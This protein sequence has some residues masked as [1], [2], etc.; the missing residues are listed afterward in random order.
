MRRAALVL[1]LGVAG[2][3]WAEEEGAGEST[4]QWPTN[5]DTLP[6][7]DDEGA[8]RSLLRRACAPL[9]SVTAAY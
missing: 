4:K 9:R 3:C 5:E 6:E 8:R 7:K 2:R 1:L